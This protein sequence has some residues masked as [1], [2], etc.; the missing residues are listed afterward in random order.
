MKRSLSH[1][2]VAAIFTLTLFSCME[3]QDFGQIDDLNVTPTLAS[4]IFYLESDEETIN[5]VGAFNTFYS[6]TVNF[7]AFNQEFVAERLLEGVIIYEIENTTSKRLRIDIEF[8]DESGVQL[9][10][11]SFDP[12]EAYPSETLIREVFYGPGGESLS[13]LA[14][15]SSLRVTG[16]NLGDATSVSSQ[17]EP[18]IVVRSGAEFLFRLK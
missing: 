8:L 3:E 11:E 16:R 12:I 10:S 7:D 17:P 6:K 13:I 15:T 5:S 14:N 9:Y 2:L 1:I 4:G 18:R